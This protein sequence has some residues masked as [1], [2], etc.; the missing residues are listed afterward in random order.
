[1]G[2]IILFLLFVLAVYGWL[3]AQ[4]SASKRSST[5]ATADPETMVSC[6]YCG[7]HVPLKESV[8]GGGRYYCGEEHRRLDAGGRRD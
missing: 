3:R 2:K 4:R 7:L 5:N 6:T 1:V 8:S